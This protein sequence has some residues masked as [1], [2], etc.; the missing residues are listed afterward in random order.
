L[1]ISYNTQCQKIFP[2][3]D[4]PDPALKAKKEV[5]GRGKEGGAGKEAE[6]GLMGIAQPQR[7]YALKKQAGKKLKF[8]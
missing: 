5:K 7:R 2:N 3:V 4:T 6:W 1:V 8:L